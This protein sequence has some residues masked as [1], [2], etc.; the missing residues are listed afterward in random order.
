MCFTRFSNRA[1]LDNAVAI[2]R[3]LLDRGADPNA[4][5]KAGD[6]NYTA[7]V[8][9]AG[10]GEQDSPRQPCA[11]E[12]FGLLLERG[13]RPFD[14]QVLYNTHFS[15][16]ML[17]W[18]DLVHRYTV[19]EGQ[20]AVWADP[21]WSMLGMGGYGPGA[22]FILNCALEKNDLVLAEWALA[23]GA[24]PDPGVYSHPKFHPKHTL[25]ERAVLEGKAE[26]AA[27][28]ANYGAQQ[29]V[30]VLDDE[31]AFIAACMR[32]DRDEIRRQLHEH[33]EYLRSPRAIFIAARRDRADVVAHLLDLGV[34]LEIE[35]PHKNRTLHEAA[36]ANALSVVQ[37]L[38]ERGA[39]VDP[40]E[41]EYGAA[42]IGFAAYG[43]KLEVLEYL[44]RYSRNVWTLTFRGYVDRLREVL[45]A[46]PS[47][48][49]AASSDGMTP[50][51]WLPDDEGKALAIAKL[52]LEH[53]ANPAAVSKDG[54]TAADWARKRGM[55]GVARLLAVEKPD[56]A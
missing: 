31:E 56:P 44:S 12:L 54:S 47:L 14:I 37:L 8:G 19:M 7:L 33:P 39:E 20:G 15:G 5:Y 30:A 51:W 3:L 48:A 43:D 46:D 16:D 22:Y 41:S 11:L 38:I 28:L 13:A 27:L 26:M 42:P 49:R 55:L 50:L 45:R 53:G 25:Y 52:L 23:R 4:F 2:G 40:R 21:N 10:E 6:A 24:R 35:G 29:S 17:W 9:V 32:L 18:L 36:G 34:P 1:T